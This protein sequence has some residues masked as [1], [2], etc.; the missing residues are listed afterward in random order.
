MVFRVKFQLKLS[1]SKKGHGH[2]RSVGMM[3]PP[4]EHSGVSFLLCNGYFWGA[5]LANNCT[6]LF[7]QSCQPQMNNYVSEM[8][9]SLFLY[10]IN[11]RLI[12]I[13]VDNL[14]M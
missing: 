3:P 9:T 12:I 14:H 1:L 7:V 8:T 6:E 10:E 5:C 11:W 2:S 4:R 13:T